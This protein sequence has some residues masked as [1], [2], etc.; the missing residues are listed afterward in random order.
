METDQ[1]QNLDALVAAV[2]R[3]RKAIETGCLDDSPRF[4][5][6]PKGC[7]DITSDLLG[8][9]LESLGFGQFDHIC[10][11][12]DDWRHAWIEGQGLIIDVTADQCEDGPG[13]VVVAPQ[14]PWHL[15][16]TDRDNR[17]PAHIDQ[18]QFDSARTTYE[19]IL[20]AIASLPN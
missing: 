12:R 9:Y 20:A 13:P 10:G 11:Q 17:G 7:C 14:S 4:A 8:T 1:S 18:Y 3:F 2:S 19:R 5:Y 16:F 6:F 15:L